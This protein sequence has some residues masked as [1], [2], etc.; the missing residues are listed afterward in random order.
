MITGAGLVA[1]AVA[2]ALL[3]C[4]AHAVTRR[5]LMRP[6][7]APW[8]NRVMAALTTAIVIVVLGWRV[9]LRWE[10][11]PYGLLVVSGVPLAIVD[12]AERRLPQV[13]VLPL[14]PALLAS[15]SGISALRHDASPLVRAIEAMVAL[16]GVH[17]VLALAVPGGMGAGDVKLAGAVG[18]A[19]G[20]SGWGTTFTTLVWA[21]LILTAVMLGARLRRPSEPLGTFAYGPCLL[22]GAV[23]AIALGGG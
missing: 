10:L 11:V 12:I 8:A 21:F 20:W 1:C 4:G 18:L 19:T 17:L 2:G 16:G 9:G 7:S 13:A 6:D 23:A 22:A 3:G 5:L 15:L 14:Y